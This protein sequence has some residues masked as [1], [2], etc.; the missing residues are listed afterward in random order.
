MASPL[1]PPLCGS[2]LWGEPAINLGFPFQPH[3]EPQPRLSV[4]DPLRPSWM[5]RLAEADFSKACVAD[6]VCN[7]C[8]GAAFCD[9]CCA[10]HHRGHDTSAA[11]DHDNAAAHR[12]DSFCTGCRVAFC[13]ELCAHHPAGEGGEGHEVIPV[14]EFDRWYCARGTGSEP[15]F[16][17][18]D[19]VQ[20]GD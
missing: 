11:M 16:P 1:L 6:R 10:E 18:F 8:G 14:D 13:S 17:E 19:G 2:G 9:H 20:V 15:W 12:R 4:F 7:T 5:S 3:P